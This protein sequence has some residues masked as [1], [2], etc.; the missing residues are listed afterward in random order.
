MKNDKNKEFK[1]RLYLLILRT[2]KLVENAKKSQTTKIVG[3]QLIRSITSILGN[4]VEGYAAS[5]KKD[6]TNYFTYSLKSANE[7]KVWVSLLR[8]TENSERK[9]A[10]AILKELGEVSNIF[11]SSILTLR[12]KRNI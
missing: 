7:S 10:D 8:D 3:D 5:S 4:Y 6:Y 11:G 1:K 2:I 9:E 12:G